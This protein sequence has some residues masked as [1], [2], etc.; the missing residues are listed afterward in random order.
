MYNLYCNLFKIPTY[1]N[2]KLLILGWGTYTSMEKKHFLKFAE[3]TKAHLI[4]YLFKWKT[5]TPTHLFAQTAS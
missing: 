1:K 4:I 5:I 2:V 3:F